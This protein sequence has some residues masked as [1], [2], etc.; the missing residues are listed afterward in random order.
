MIAL[1]LSFD[2]TFYQREIWAKPVTFINQT[3]LTKKLWIS[4]D[5]SAY[6]KDKPIE[7]ALWK[8]GNIKSSMATKEDG[9]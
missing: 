9:G 2:S 1:T 3:G 6:F 5:W 4:G 8:A 7:G